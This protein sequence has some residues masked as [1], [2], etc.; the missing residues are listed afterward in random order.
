MHSRKD[1]GQRLM[2]WMFKFSKFEYTFKYK[3]GRLNH[4]ADALSPNPPEQ[5]KSK[6]EEINEKLPENENINDESREK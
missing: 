4:N 1:P 5:K 2:R 3:P 6:E